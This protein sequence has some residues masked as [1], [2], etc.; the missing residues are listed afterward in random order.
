[1]SLQRVGTIGFA[2]AVLAGA[3]GSASPANADWRHHRGPWGHLWHAHVW[4]HP[5]AP[6][7]Y[8]APAPVYYGPPRVAYASPAVV[9][10]PPPVYYPPA[11]SIGVR[12]P[13]PDRGRRFI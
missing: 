4:L 8:Y 3:L 7:V 9:Y 13:S 5:W 10:A 12:I 6:P 1:V 2:T 11:V